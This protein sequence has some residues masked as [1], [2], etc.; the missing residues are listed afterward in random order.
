MRHMQKLQAG[1]TL[2]ELV[3]VVVAAGILI[4]IILLSNR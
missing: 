1:F 3:V 2:L 4:A